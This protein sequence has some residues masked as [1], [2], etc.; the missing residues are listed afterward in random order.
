MVLRW[1]LALAVFA[2]APARAVIIASGDGSGNTT[3]PADDPGFVHAGRIGG[4]S[5]V[6]LGNGWVL[7][8]NH[9]GANDS[10]IAGT[11]YPHIPGSAI[12][13]QNPDLSYADL[14]VFRLALPPALPTL[15]IRASAPPP[16]AS[17]VMIGHGRNRG[18]ATSWMGIP[19][20]YWAGTNAIRWGTNL[21]SQ[22]GLDVNLPGTKTR[23]FD[24]D[25]TQSGGTTHEAQ[26]AV[27]DSGGAVFLKNGT[28]WELA[29][30]LYAIAPFDGQPA[31]TALY[32]NLSYAV[33]LSYYRTQLV[34]I[35]AQPVCND[36]LDNDFD[37]KIDA[38]Q[39][40]G[41][42]DAS[43]A[44]ESLD[45]DD[46]IDND[47]DGLVDV[48][49]D[50]GCLNRL[51]FSRENPACNDGI[52]NDM[53]GLIDFPADP[54]CSAAWLESE[55]PAASGCGLLGAEPLALAAALRALARR[56][57]RLRGP[58]ASRRRAGGMA[59]H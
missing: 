10:L 32:G 12:Q 15:A 16:G 31:N 1:L 14:L 47:F 49:N 18:A 5:A 36:G 38:A 11:I 24:T 29:G 50:P 6:Y 4:L 13:L 58:R 51:G 41:C 3:A 26:A 59:S 33:D 53:D 44:W 20:W 42:R 9:V 56:V 46:G 57:S 55:S 37:G 17:L 43:D 21:V 7:T 8:A 22:N 45:C 39:D 28:Q 54:Q 30:I 35:V 48:G 27:G 23:S 40:E 52:D 2:A 19:G 25:F 34:S